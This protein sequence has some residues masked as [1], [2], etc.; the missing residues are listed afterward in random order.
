MCMRSIARGGWSH[1]L[2]NTAI[3]L[4]RSL[5]LSM[6]LYIIFIEIQD[7]RKVLHFYTP[8]R[9]IHVYITL[10]VFD[11]SCYEINV[12]RNNKFVRFQ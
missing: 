4:T 6:S 3:N 9:A 10:T 7:T 8:K 11:G 12:S 5:A 2:S 1:R